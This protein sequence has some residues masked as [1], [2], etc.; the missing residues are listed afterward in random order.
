MEMVRLRTVDGFT[1]DM[2]FEF[3]RVN[4]ELKIERDSHGNIIVMAPTGFET[5]NRN[6]G[7]IAALYNWNQE[8][9]LGRVGDS[10]TGYRLPNGAVR[11]PDASWVSNERLAR[12]NPEALKKFPALCPDFVI[13]LRSEHDSLPALK[14]KMKE[15]M[16]N[17]C[18]LGWLIDPEHGQV[19][20][21]RGNGTI[22]LVD[23][24]DAILDGEDVL[25]GFELSLSLFK[26]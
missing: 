26:G 17:G 14:E 21:F 23:S 24:F 10:S 12:I 1:D 8:S 5:G 18:R 20:I 25:P 6:S 4:D 3:C 13:E 16:D 19:F 11:S 22:A 9:S 2:F 15:Y 7:I